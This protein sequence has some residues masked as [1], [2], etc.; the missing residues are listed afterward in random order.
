MKP[1]ALQDAIKLQAAKRK[2]RAAKKEWKDPYVKKHVITADEFKQAKESKKSTLQMPHV[3]SCLTSSAPSETNNMVQQM[4][5]MKHEFSKEKESLLSDMMN[6][7]GEIDQCRSLMEGIRD[8][9]VATKSN[10]DDTEQIRTEMH[11]LRDALKTAT[12]RNHSKHDET[13]DYNEEIEQCRSEMED[14]R[15]RLAN[16][17]DVDNLRKEISSLRKFV[18]DL[19]DENKSL[20]QDVLKMANSV[21]KP[22][23]GPENYSTPPGTPGEKSR[24]SSASEALAMTPG[25]Y[26]MRKELEN[27]AN[28]LELPTS[29]KKKITIEPL[30]AAK[31][32]RWQGRD[33]ILRD[34]LKEDNPTPLQTTQLFPKK[35]MSIKEIDGHMIVHFKKRIYVPPKLREKTTKWFLDNHSKNLALLEMSNNFIWPKME[36]DLDNIYT[37]KGLQQ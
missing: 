14:L 2:K 11:S 9:L 29:P 16:K 30:T 19:Q 27:I 21:W 23:K 22:S 35:L 6:F 24:Y 4:Q 12:K 10:H 8:E 25:T 20:K 32:A 28:G 17:V 18:S 5:K 36:H 31:I 26:K 34:F 13:K 37:Q 15:D 1:Q 7:K 33:K 3:S